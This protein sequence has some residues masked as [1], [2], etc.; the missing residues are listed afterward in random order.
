MGVDRDVSTPYCWSSSGDDVD[1]LSLKKRHA[2]EASGSILC[3]TRQNDPLSPHCMS[4]PLTTV[5]TGIDGS[6]FVWTV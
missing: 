2:N 5:I 4:K 6:Q 3:D 1:W